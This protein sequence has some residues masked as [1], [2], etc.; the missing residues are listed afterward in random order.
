MIVYLVG[1]PGSG[2]S[3]VGRE[4]AGRLGVPFVDLDAEIERRHGST[5]PEI[6]AVE[7]EAGLL[8]EDEVRAGL[9]AGRFDLGAE[10]AR[11]AA[12]LGPVVREGE[13]VLV[14]GDLPA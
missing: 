8:D 2:K 4:V 7:G 1:M 11:V 9:G 6:F 3:T 13:R 10:L 14:L 12:G 5:V